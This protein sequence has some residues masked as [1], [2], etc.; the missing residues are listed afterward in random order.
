MLYKGTQY[1]KKRHTLFALV[2]TQPILHLHQTSSDLRRSPLELPSITEMIYY[3]TCSLVINIQCTRYK[4]AFNKR[5]KRIM[6]QNKFVKIY[7]EKN[8]NSM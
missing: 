6:C 1:L 5:F 7:S 3:Y 4:N 2:V 8:Y